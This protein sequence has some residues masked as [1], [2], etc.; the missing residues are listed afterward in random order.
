MSN[1]KYPFEEGDIYY[2]LYHKAG[3]LPSDAR[4]RATW[5]ESVWDDG[6]IE[7]WE[8]ALQEDPDCDPGSRLFS[9]SQMA[10]I[11]QAFAKYPGERWLYRHVDFMN[12][13]EGTDM[14]NIFQNQI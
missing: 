3:T 2:A 7:L 14:L 11:E 9:P 4:T 10:R 5:L 1:I 13:P 6:S 12:H 8:L